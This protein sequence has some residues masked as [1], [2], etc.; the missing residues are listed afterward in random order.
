MTNGHDR[1]YIS[2]AGCDRGTG[3]VSMRASAGCAARNTLERF[4]LSAVL[5]TLARI[6]HRIE[7]IGAANQRKSLCCNNLS[8]THG[9][10]RCRQS[11]AQISLNLHPW[12]D[13]K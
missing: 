5:G 11:V 7:C 4:E 1:L 10:P 8:P 6:S 12:K 9:A 3:A 13:A 2:P